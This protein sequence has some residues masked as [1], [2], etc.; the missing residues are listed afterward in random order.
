M[1]CMVTRPTLHRH[2]YQAGSGPAWVTVH[3]VAAVI[4][5][6]RAGVTMYPLSQPVAMFAADGAP[7]YNS[8]YLPGYQAA[9]LPGGQIPLE[10]PPLAAMLDLTNRQSWDRP[11]F[12][13]SAS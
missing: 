10:L 8:G 5:S 3:A 2:S 9:Q 6:P 7:Y 11:V 12:F 13:P 1:G 4:Q